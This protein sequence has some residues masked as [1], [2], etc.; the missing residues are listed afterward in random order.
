MHNFN[1]L[2]LCCGRNKEESFA[3]LN[4]LLETNVNNKVLNFE[5]ENDCSSSLNAESDEEGVDF[6][7]CEAIKKDVRRN[8]GG[9]FL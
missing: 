4:Q 9:N 2:G 3:V 8:G 1:S 5:P 7:E 6:L